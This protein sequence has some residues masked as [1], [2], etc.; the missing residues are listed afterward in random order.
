MA[1]PNP[2]RADSARPVLIHHTPLQGDDPGID[3]R[4]LIPAWI[5]SGVVHVAALSV[6]LLVTFG[7][8]GGWVGREVVNLVT[9][10]GDPNKQENFYED[11]L[12]DDPET[13]LNY[14]VERIDTISVPGPINPNELPGLATGQTNVPP[15]NIPAPS[16]F[17]E[18]VG[19]S[20]L[21][22]GKDGKGPMIDGPNGGYP[23]GVRN[24]PGGLD[25]RSGSTREQL[26]GM[27]GGN[28]RSE[29]AVAMGLKWFIRHQALDG[30]WGMNDFH[31]AGKCNCTGASGNYAVAGT[32]FGLLP[33][34]GAGETHKGTGKANRYAK[35]VE[36]ALKWLITRQGADG[37]FS[38]NGYEHAIATIA[39]CE[40]YGLTADPVLKGPAQRAIN[41]CVGWQNVS[42]GFRYS[43]R[44]AGDLSVSGWFV[45]ALKSGH[46]AG[47]TVPNAT[48]AGVNNF[49][50]SVSNPEG[51]GYMYLPTQKEPAVTMTPVGL[52]SRQ[53]M[54]WQPRN[55][56]LV[57][58][59]EYLRKLPPSANFKNIY[60][61]YYATQVMYHMAPMNPEGWN[62][63][64]KRMR[65]LLIDSQDTGLTPERPDQKG[66]WSAEGDRWGG[67]LGRLGYTSLCLLTLEV[68]YRHL[69]L[70]RRELGAM[71]DEAL[72][73]D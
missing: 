60:Y 44:E 31:V 64:N 48:W 34:L 20:P 41:C 66:S 33:L 71:K 15:M 2:G 46:L 62:D 40:A 51:S 32:G 10:V 9:E 17:G 8:S 36:R 68:Y 65:D 58:G 53:Y 56:G 39:I 14:P 27:F 35:N 11:G 67:Q 29:A 6:L 28:Q 26:L 57:K 55:M 1:S 25:G 7:A 54:G 43:A 30:H 59:T 69:P 63:W 47:L 72:Q 5:V 21:V 61:Y 22:P 52:L 24:V 37:S 42:G 23:R 50:D 73:R 70:Y 13:P 45:Q 16:G 19:A 4:K 49:L 3:L 38:T 18:G 12:G